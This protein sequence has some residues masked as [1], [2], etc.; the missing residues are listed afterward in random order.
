[1]YSK[2][3]NELGE[4]QDKICAL[5]DVAFSQ[6]TLCAQCSGSCPEGI[7]LLSVMRGIRAMGSTAG[8]APRDSVTPTDGTP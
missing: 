1:M 7:N 5:S 4:L 6:C 3:E 2:L 8:V